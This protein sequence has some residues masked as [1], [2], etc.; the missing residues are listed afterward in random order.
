MSNTIENDHYLKMQDKC[1]LFSIPLPRFLLR[2]YNEFHSLSPFALKFCSLL[3]AKGILV[4]FETGVDV[5]VDGGAGVTC[6]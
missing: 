5:D 6:F 3:N 4:G 2:R 1:L